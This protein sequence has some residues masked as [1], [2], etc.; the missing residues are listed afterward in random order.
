MSWIDL[1]LPATG[2]AGAFNVL[3]HSP[4]VDGPGAEREKTSTSWVIEQTNAWL[5][6]GQTDL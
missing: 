6:L 2:P 5:L 3:E 4:D 1:L